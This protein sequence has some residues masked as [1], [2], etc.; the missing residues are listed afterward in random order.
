MSIC[1]SVLAALAAPVLGALGGAQHARAVAP[2][3]AQVQKGVL[4]VWM[5]AGFNG[6]PRIPHEIGRRGSIGAILFGAPLN[7]PPAKHKNNKILWVPRHSSKTAAALWIKMQ[8]MNSTQTIGAAVT[9]IVKSGP[10]PSYVD[11][12]SPGCWRVTL[13]WSGQKDSLDLSY[14]RPTG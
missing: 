10:G 14:V 12:P 13:T 1:L 2:C 6:A 8:K 5:R 3:S 9:R 7:A 11:A 4:P